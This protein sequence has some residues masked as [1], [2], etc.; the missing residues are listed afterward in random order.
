MV[1]SNFPVL[2]FPSPYMY[3]LTGR[4]FMSTATFNPSA[5]FPHRTGTLRRS[6][7]RRFLNFLRSGNSRDSE[8]GLL[9]SSEEIRRYSEEASSITTPTVE[10]LIDLDDRG[11]VAQEIRQQTTPIVRRPVQGGAQQGQAPFFDFA[12]WEREHSTRLAGNMVRQPLTASAETTTYLIHTNLSLQ[13]SPPQE[14][15][16][17]HD[18]KP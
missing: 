16:S 11:H 14:D 18:S 12:Q 2:P 1:H 10:A 17:T 9:G 3:K 13:Q 15:E 4:Q 5:S 6:R 7:G 8:E